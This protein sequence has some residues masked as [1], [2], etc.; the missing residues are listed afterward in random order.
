MVLLCLA[1]TANLYPTLRVK[2][3]STI[4]NK[5]LPHHHLLLSIL[6]NRTN[7]KY[8]PW[9]G[10]RLRPVEKGEGEYEVLLSRSSGEEDEVVPGGGDT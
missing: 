1:N 6:Q 2:S 7:T 8:K 5:N 10:M 9:R 3:F 4:Y